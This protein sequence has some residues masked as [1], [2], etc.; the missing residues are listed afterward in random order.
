MSLKTQIMVAVV[1]VAAL[2]WIANMVRKQALDIRFALSW[3]TVGGV[4][5]ILDVF[6]GHIKY[7]V[8]VLGI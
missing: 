3:V 1:I 6:E 7:H 8:D 4:V 2:V 5:F